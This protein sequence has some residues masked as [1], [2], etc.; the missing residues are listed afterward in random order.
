M[1]VSLKAG[2]TLYHLAVTAAEREQLLVALELAV[3]VKRREPESFLLVADVDAD[4]ADRL[5]DSL[6]LCAAA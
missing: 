5:A 6:F 3:A 2:P 1:V 4:L